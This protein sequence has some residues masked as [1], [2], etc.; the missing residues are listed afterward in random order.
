MTQDIVTQSLTK[1]LD[2]SGDDEAGAR[3]VL[4]LLQDGLHHAEHVHLVEEREAVRVLRDLTHD[5]QG[6]QLRERVAGVSH[7]LEKGREHAKGLQPERENQ[8][9]I[10]L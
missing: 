1:E 5:L 9:S 10:F 4:G 6:V 3:L 7:L 2:V 8:S